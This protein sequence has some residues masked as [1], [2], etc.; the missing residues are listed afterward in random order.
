MNTALITKLIFSQT[1][2]LSKGCD[3][4]MGMY[5][6][7]W[8]RALHHQN[9]W[10]RVC[11]SVTLCHNTAPCWSIYSLQ[12]PVVPDT[13]N[14]GWTDDCQQIFYWKTWWK[15]IWMFNREWEKKSFILHAPARNDLPASHSDLSHP[16]L[17]WHTLHTSHYYKLLATYYL[18]W[19]T[20]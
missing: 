1:W 12:R 5:G 16:N 17:W 9:T 8:I 4:A 18:L 2:S 3:I 13:T 20:A 14:F 15:I 11:M 7:Y 10:A 19:W 6:F